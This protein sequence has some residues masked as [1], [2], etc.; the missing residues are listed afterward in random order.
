M[1]PRRKRSGF[2]PLFLGVFVAVLA[3][4]VLIAW[5]LYRADFR[6]RYYVDEWWGQV[7][8]YVAPVP[9][10][11]PTAVPVSQSTLA[12]SL[13]ATVTPSPTIPSFPTPG[14]TA[15][16]TP[17]PPTLTPLP[18][19]VLLTGVQYEK[20]AFNN[21]GPA[22]LSMN[23][24]YWGWLE[25]QM[26][27]ADTVKPNAYDRNVSPRELYDYLLTQGFDAYI[28]VGGNLDTLKRF[29]SAGYPVLMEKGYTCESGE[30]CAGWFGHYSVVT[31][32]D[33][34][35]Q[36][37]ITQDSFLGPDLKRSYAYIEENWRAFNHL[38]LIV[39]PTGAERDAEVRTLLSTAADVD[40]D[41]RATLERARAEANTLV[42]QE[43]AFAWFNVGT[44][45][46]Y[47]N[48]YG[49]AAAAYDQA[50]QIGLPYRM[51]WYQF[52][53][54]RAYY[55]TARYQDVVD[56]AT[57]AI[58]AAIGE[59]G[60]EEAYYWRGQAQEMLGER[61]KAIEDYRTALVRHPGYQLAVDALT[62]LGEVP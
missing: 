51:L 22:S 32:Y 47:F 26:P 33:D 43:A 54:Y 50:R 59:P 55:Y 38:Y 17:A 27:I 48:D 20:Q 37:V 29:I 19:Q 40:A 60:L 46:V 35:T 56:L 57:F 44:N 25:G 21:C 2:W 24:S 3:V 34:A 1:S 31:G 36:Q 15:T 16:A 4:G 61:D 5:V 49:G 8:Q 7:R 13:T 14:P 45:L 62:A 52:G 18:A 53:P 6:V 28:R 42:G 23:L 30:R 58:N 12:P 39:F 11:L 9:E 10:V 41:Y